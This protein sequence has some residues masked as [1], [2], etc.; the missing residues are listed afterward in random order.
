MP[1]SSAKVLIVFGPNLVYVHGIAPQEAQELLPGI[2][3][4]S[5]ALGMN[6]I[7]MATSTSY[8]WQGNM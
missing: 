7:L 8:G 5:W 1:V 4:S 2:P 6:Y 3:S